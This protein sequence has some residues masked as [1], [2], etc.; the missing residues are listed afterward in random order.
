[1]EAVPGPEALRETL[2]QTLQTSFSELREPPVRKAAAAAA[3]APNRICTPRNWPCGPRRSA[4]LPSVPSAR[5][6][7]SGTRPPC[8]WSSS[9]Q[10]YEAPGIP[11]WK[12]NRG[13]E[14]QW[15][16]FFF[17]AKPSRF[18]L[19]RAFSADLPPPPPVLFIPHTFCMFGFPGIYFS[20]SLIASVMFDPF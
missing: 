2:G 6:C 11:A 1:M 7:T 9:D 17:S 8:H 5:A 20:L 15:F 16:Y 4:R 14:H 3:W 10:L 19:R 13:P 18:H 12:E